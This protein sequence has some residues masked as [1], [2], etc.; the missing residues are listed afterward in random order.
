MRASKESDI[1]RRVCVSPIGSYL[2][3]VYVGGWE[4][5]ALFLRSRFPPWVMG[6]VKGQV[7][8]SQVNLGYIVWGTGTGIGPASS[9][10][11]RSVWEPPFTMRK[12]GLR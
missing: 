10:L 3:H 1:C 7:K 9:G 4:K 2:I 6:Q 5:A 12:E 11:S 8:S